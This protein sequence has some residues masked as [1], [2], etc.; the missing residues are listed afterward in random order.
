MPHLYYPLLFIVLVPPLVCTP[1]E[2]RLLSSGRV[3]VCTN[4]RWGAI[5]SDSFDNLDAAVVCRQLGLLS[6]GETIADDWLTLL[7]IVKWY[8][9]YNCAPG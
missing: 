4:G 9:N 6:E 3:E 1:G 5:C 2:I 8:K 7:T